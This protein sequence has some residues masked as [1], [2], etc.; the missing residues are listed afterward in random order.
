MI[1]QH[2]LAYL[3]GLEGLALLRGWAGDFDQ[4][5]IEARLAEVRRLLDEPALTQHPGV[6]V[7][8]GD[9]G[10]GYAQWASTYDEPRNGL[11]DLDEPI[12]RPLLDAVAPGVALDAACGTG[13]FAEL[14]AARHQ[15]IGVDG[16]PEMLERARVR[17][18]AA[19]FRL[20]DLDQL[21]VPDVSVDLLTTGLALSHVPDLRPVLTEFARALRPGGH[22]I[23]ADVHPELILLGSVVKSLGPDGEPGLVPTYRHSAG[24][25]L[26]AALPHGF[27]LRHCEEAPVRPT[28]A[29]QSAPRDPMPDDLDPGPWADWPWSLMGLIPAA[30]GAVGQGPAITVWHFTLE[31]GS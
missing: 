10:T 4:E 9:S 1:Y 5:F 31:P 3:L 21:P 29:D 11:F 23:I 7:G 24:D 22:L 28:H 17:V 30:A 25:L 8:R 27:R 18:P 19:D 26:R 20:G 15:V 6:P 14:L 16:S 13:R 2:P 12:V